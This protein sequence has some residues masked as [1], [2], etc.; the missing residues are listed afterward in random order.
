[1]NDDDDD[2]AIAEEEEEVWCPAP[3]RRKRQSPTRCLRRPS[4]LVSLA[5]GVIG[6]A[7]EFTN[8]DYQT[9]TLSFFLSVQVAR[10]AVIFVFSVHLLSWRLLSFAWGWTRATQ[11]SHRQT[12]RRGPGFVDMVEIRPPAKL[13]SQV[14]FGRPGLITG[15]LGGADGQNAESRT[16]A[17]QRSPRRAF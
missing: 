11:R 12:I 9:D 14:N 3:K 16:L 15:H 6:A 8:Y 7:Y 13:S 1:M 17:T 10:V 2:D 4:F 5:A